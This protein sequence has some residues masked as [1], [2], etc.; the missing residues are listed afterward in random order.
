VGQPPIRELCKGKHRPLIIVDD[1]NRPTPAASVMPFLLQQFREAG[2]APKD[3][4]ILMARGSHGEPRRD[5]MIQKIG[6]DA[7][8]SCRF[9][10]HDPTRNTVKVG[11]TTLGTPV[12]VNRE[13]LSADFI[14]GI[15]GVYPNNTAGFGGGSKLVLG[16]LDLRVI[17][18]LHRRHKGSGWGNEALRCDFRRDLDE[19]AG[20]IRLQSLITLHVNAKRESIRMV[21][22]DYSL[23]F[24]QEVA[25]AREV[26]R[27]PKPDGADV[28]IS[29]A[30]PNDLSLTFIHMK[31]VYPLRHASSRASRIVLGSCTEG[32]GFHGV[33]PI[34][35][36]PMFHE[37]RDR[38]RRISLMSPSEIAGKIKGKLARRFRAES[39]GHAERKGD[40]IRP[41]PKNPIWL[42]RIG[43]HRD[44]LPSP[45]RGIRVL[46]SWPK[47]LEAVQKEQRGRN[48]LKAVVYPCAPLQV[49]E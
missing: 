8:S 46:D 16:I 10:L 31:G 45:V 23:Y 18:L 21:T 35:R 32:E 5:S 15:G 3:V 24:P 29:N 2:I 26:F 14:M 9:L 40:E 4:T 48:H 33:Y 12:L 49:L 36:S 28:V 6:F 47:I 34:V 25:F 44:T 11:T 37:Q 20:M 27:A 1:I 39:N 43:S 13:I 19:I 30:F 38:L 22:G 17:S 41:E 42:Y 7:A